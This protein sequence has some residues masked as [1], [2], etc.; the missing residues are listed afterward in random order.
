MDTKGILIDCG[1]CGKRNRLSY[2]ALRKETR[3]GS[4]KNP[5]EPPRQTV[6]IATDEQFEALVT[7]SSL[8]VLVDFWAEWCGPC[9]M[10]APELEKVAARAQGQVVVAK[11][12]TEWLQGTAAKFNITSIPTLSLMREGLEV[13]RLMGARPASDILT[14]LERLLR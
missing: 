7:E 5:L 14:F 3:C 4:C 13:E 2:K 10:V 12:N 1:S 9:K 11:V 8:P 6:H